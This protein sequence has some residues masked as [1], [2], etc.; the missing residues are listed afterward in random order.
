M[1]CSVP[2]VILVA[3]LCLDSLPAVSQQNN[4]AAELAAIQQSAQAGDAQAEYEL[5]VRYLLGVKGLLA[6]DSAQSLVWFQKSAEQGYLKAEQSLASEFEHGFHG[7]QN[8]EQATY[9]YRKLAEQGDKESEWILGNAYEFGRG[10]PVDPVHARM[11]LEKAANENWGPQF[12]FAKARLKRL[13]SPWYPSELARYANYAGPSPKPPAGTCLKDDPVGLYS[14][15]QANLAANGDPREAGNL[16]SL[17]WQEGKFEESYKWQ[18]RATEY[19]GIPSRGL[20]DDAVKLYRQS[21]SDAGAATPPEYFATGSPTS[22][23]TPID[24]AAVA[25]IDILKLLQSAGAGTLNPKGTRFEQDRRG[26]FDFWRGCAGVK[27]KMDRVNI[28]Q[29]EQACGELVRQGFLV[30]ENDPQSQSANAV[31]VVLAPQAVSNPVEL[32]F[33]MSAL[34]RGCGWYAPTV[35]KGSGGDTCGDLAV[36]LYRLGN[37]PAAMAVLEFAPGCY[38]VDERTKNPRNGCIL[39]NQIATEIFA[40]EPTH[41]V[42]LMLKSCNSIHDRDSCA[43]LNQHGA[44]VDMTPVLE[45]ENQQHA[46]LEAYREEG[47]ARLQQA[48]A[49]AQARR[50]AFF[51]ALSSLAGSSDPNALVN[52]GNQQAIAIRAAVSAPPNLFQAAT[53]LTPSVSNASLVQTA[54]PAAVTGGTTSVTSG[55]SSGSSASPGPASTPGGASSTGTGGSGRAVSS[56]LSPLPA[57]CVRQFWDSR[58]YNWLSFE[59]NCD[60]P[61]SVT[62]I[63][64]H[65]VGWAMT[66]AI[67]LAPGAQGTTGR[68]SSD[69]NQAGGYDYYVCPANS[70]PV[71]LSG[72]IFSSNVSEYRCKPQ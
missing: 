63:F 4:Q 33:F 37:A 13:G 7:C 27:S 50:N 26:E 5:A 53:T 59:N 29:G 30:G 47:R 61:V 2:A 60:Q 21:A 22:L 1:K 66:G 43:F 42:K 52:T 40:L 25:P 8:F 3:C 65:N 54:A 51:S 62:F 68:S 70:V 35:E 20:F 45:A 55:P 58:S 49:D 41:L 72:N 14:A 10:V 34:V 23:R 39:G 36:A 57:S 46:D 56:Y 44:N 38:S 64:N 32:Q 16:G 17:L 9:W 28:D 11:W 15:A 6:A 71:D 48:Q 24:F 31:T 69:I 12:N 19:L 18:A 67:L